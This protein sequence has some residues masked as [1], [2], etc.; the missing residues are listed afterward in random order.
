V[1]GGG[2]FKF[3]ERKFGAFDTMERNL[4]VVHKMLNSIYLL[5]K[6]ENNMFVNTIISSL[7]S[8]VLD[9]FWF[10]YCLFSTIKVIIFIKIHV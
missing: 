10:I 7:V 3:K 9:N 1:G 2:I 8:K 6:K 4:E 5:N